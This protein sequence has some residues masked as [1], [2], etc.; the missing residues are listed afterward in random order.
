MKLINLYNRISSWLQKGLPYIS[1][2]LLGIAGLLMFSEVI[3]RYFFHISHS[4][5]E[6]IPRYLVIT[7]TFLMAPVMLKLGRHINVDLVPELLKG[8]QK[9]I[10]TLI[11]NCLVLAAC[12]YMLIAGINGVTYHFNAGTV[13]SGE[14]EMPIWILITAFLVGSALLVMYSIELLIR[15]VVALIKSEHANNMEAP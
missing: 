6:E 13:S 1:G 7:A 2:L 14:L 12:V 8:R 3:T 11:I 5:M 15:S 9:R 4:Y 10:L